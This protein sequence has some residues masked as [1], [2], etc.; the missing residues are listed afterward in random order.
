MCSYKQNIFSLH[1]GMNWDS[2]AKF[3]IVGISQD[4]NTVEIWEMT[5]HLRTAVQANFK[6]ICGKQ[7][8]RKEKELSR[9]SIIDSEER[10][11]KTIAATKE[12]ENP[13]AFSST[14]KS[15]SKNI[16]TGNVVGSSVSYCNKL[17]NFLKTF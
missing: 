13:F 2:K 14:Q 7:E 11:L 17:K 4:Y 12:H 9:K 16:V 15:K 1:A 8:T 5:A 6:N 3:E 10:V